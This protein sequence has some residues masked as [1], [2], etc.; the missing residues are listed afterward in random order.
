MFDRDDREH[1]A[2]LR[3]WDDVQKNL[4]YNEDSR[5]LPA[6]VTMLRPALGHLNAFTKIFSEKLG[7]Y[8]DAAF[9]WGAVDLL[10]EV[11]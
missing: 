10:L 6:Q 3:S 2:R 4:F 1:I 5:A 11:S 9:L 8:L 7:P